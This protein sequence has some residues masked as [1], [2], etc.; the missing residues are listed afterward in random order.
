MRVCLFECVVHP[1]SSFLFHNHDCV[2]TNHSSKQ[3]IFYLNMNNSKSTTILSHTVL[4]NI[5]SK[6]CEDDPV[7]YNLIRLALISKKWAST[8][9]PQHFYLIRSSNFDQLIRLAAKPL[10]NHAGAR[11]SA[12][13]DKQGGQPAGDAVRVAQHQ[14]APVSAALSEHAVHIVLQLQL[15]E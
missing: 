7:V 4:A 1:Q 15:G 2:S 6:I 5:I 11:E 14:A 3:P 13:A 9:V 10:F 12:A 8:L